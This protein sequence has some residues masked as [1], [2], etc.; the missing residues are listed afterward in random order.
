MSF[1]EEGK[2]APVFSLK[3][4]D[5]EIHKL[6]DIEEDYIVLFF[7]PRDNTP[8][9]TIE[10]VNFSKDINKYK[11]LNTK[12]IGISGGDEKTK[13][14]FCTKHKLKA[15]M[16]SDTDYKISEKYGVYGE[17]KFMGKKYLGISRV[18]FILDDKR[19]VIKVYDKVKPLVHS[20]EILEYLKS[21]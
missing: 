11:K 8:G 3:D 1:I 18:T 14:K 12:V 15:L 9:C 19:K 6:K 5:G 4:K 7:Y 16:L 20:K 17:K 13:T 21:L 10:S 2:K